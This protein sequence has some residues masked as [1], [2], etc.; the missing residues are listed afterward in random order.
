MG[1]DH[2]PT[3]NLNLMALGGP[4]LWLLLL[5]GLFGTAMFVERLVFLH[6]GQIRAG[7]FLDGIR[8]ILEG[9]RLVEAI[10]V[11]EET[12][13]PVAAL[14]KTALIHHDKPDEEVRA[15]LQEA[16]LVEMPLLER[17]LGSIAAVAQV[18]PV[19]GLFGT[20]LG[21]IEVFAAF[22]RGGEF[23][24]ASAIA[25]G[26]WPALVTTAAGLA[27]GVTAHLAH[28][29]LVG[30]VRAIVHDMEWASLKVLQ[31]IH[32]RRRTEVA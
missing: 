32:A 8:N 30:R 25:G 20:V 19:L 2:V 15:A 26:I 14:V 11:C 29:F 3:D 5:A 21:A 7:E 24:S 12:P 28:H 31:L 27:I 13:G 22:Q 10:T 18:A 6:R 9:D 17:R 16:A 23:A 4:V 1:D